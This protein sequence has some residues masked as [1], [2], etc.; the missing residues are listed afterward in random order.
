MRYLAEIQDA[1]DSPEL[2]DRAPGQRVGVL[3]AQGEELAR[4]CRAMLEHWESWA[5]QTHD[6]VGRDRD[7]LRVGTLP[8]SFDLIADALTDLR[9]RRPELALRVVEYPDE[10][11]L[12]AMAQGEVDLGFGTLSAE[13]VP[14]RL[15]YTPLGPL[16][17]VVIMPQEWAPRFSARLR[18]RDL[19]GVPLVVTRSGPAR[20]RLERYFAEYGDGPLTLNPAFEVGS[21]PR[22]VEMVARGFGPALV[23]RFRVAFVPSNV[24]VRPLLDGPAPLSAGVYTRRGAAL[25]K[26][27]R[28]LIA[29]ARRRFKTLS[30]KPTPQ[31]AS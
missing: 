28:D 19:D 20:R 25:G 22:L 21:T 26:L 31:R 9:R 12:E 11:L 18:L 10:R 29:T 6:A 8:G 16:P 5:S 1:F 15:T 2:M 7:A 30:R 14:P 13:G 27:A 23:S 3:T 17:W 4:R 24:V